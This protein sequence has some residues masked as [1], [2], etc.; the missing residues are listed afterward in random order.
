[1]TFFI[2]YLEEDSKH[3]NYYPA[4]L[5]MT[6]KKKNQGYEPVFWPHGVFEF[7]HVIQAR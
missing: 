2:P 3:M 1:M 7:L 4:N 6:K 5:E